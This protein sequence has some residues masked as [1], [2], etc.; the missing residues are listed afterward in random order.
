MR[1][2]DAD[3]LKKWLERWKGYLDDDMIQRMQICSKDI[4]TVEERKKGEWIKRGSSLYRC[5]ECARFSPT[6]ENF[7]PTCGADNREEKTNDDM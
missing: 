7:C 4:Q 6:Q 5:S 1:L 3:D 2:I